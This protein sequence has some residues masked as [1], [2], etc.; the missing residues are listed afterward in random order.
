M[1]LYLTD[2]EYGEGEVEEAESDSDDNTGDPR[3]LPESEY[4]FYRLSNLDFEMM[5]RKSPIFIWA[6]NHIHYKFFKTF[7]SCWL[8][9]LVFFYSGWYNGFYCKAF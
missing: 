5:T 3:Q 7:S 2:W 6:M 8:I 4:D 9:Y 1:S